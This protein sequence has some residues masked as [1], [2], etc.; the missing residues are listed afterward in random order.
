MLAKPLHPPVLKPISAHGGG[1]LSPPYL[2]FKILPFC[3]SRRA[4]IGRRTGFAKRF[5][6]VAKSGYT[7]IPM[8]TSGAYQLVD[9]ETGEKFIVWGGSDDG[10]DSPIPSK[11]VLSWSSSGPGRGKGKEERV[12]VG[13]GSGADI[14]NEA[15]PAKVAAAAVDESSL[16]RSFS[17]L[18]VQRVK[19]L[20][21]RSCLKHDD[22][23]DVI[24]QPSAA[25]KSPMQ[26]EK[27]V[28]AIRRGGK[29]LN[30]SRV[31]RDVMTARNDTETRQRRSELSNR[32]VSSY[33]ESK[34]PES[35]GYN[36][37]F[38]GWRN[39]RP[40]QSSTLESNDRMRSS[41][42][43]S[44]DGDFYSR[45]SFVDLGCNDYLI[46]SLRKQMFLRPSHIQAM[47]FKPVMEGKSCIIA[48]QS[49]S[50]KTL[51]YLAP[52]VQRLREEELQGQSKS[53]P[54]S[55]RVVILAP[56]AELASQVLNNCRSISKCG[57]PFRSIVTTGGFRQKTQLEAIEEGVDVLIATPG[58]FMYLIKEGFMELG[59]LRCVILDEV[60]ILCKD[61][62]FEAA[63][64]NLISSSPVTT[65][66]LFVTATLPVDTYNKLVDVFPDCEVIMGPGI[67]RTSIRLEEVLVDCSGEE[68]NE[69]SPDT[70]F[71]NK[72]SALV[73]LVEENPVPKTI[74]FCNK[75]E[76]CRKVENT[77]KR[78]DR[79]GARIRVLPFHSAVAQETRL[80]SIKDFIAG[81]SKDVSLFLVCTD[82][83]SRGIDFPEVDH[84]ILFDY[85]RDPSEY[86]RRVGRT[87]RGASGKGTAFVFAV[88]KQVMLARKVMDRNRKGHPLHDVP[89][90]YEFIG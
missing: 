40:S 21:K 73:Q 66:Y 1:T 44:A 41:R 59:N 82:R 78:V 28:P 87:A 35:D 50:G 56:T 80:A 39:G 54:R 12:K 55:P 49:G 25:S 53:L 52:L 11:D 72:K 10:P 36:S 2:N 63:L 23:E 62:D 29:D 33:A 15:S 3:L 48:D 7:R 42:K 32:K 64:Q 60:D 77:L 57:V 26:E 4:H 22:I 70:A 20:A 85:P 31:P 9:E 24:G 30:V 71:S 69:K 76:T 45:K 79:K 5:E 67:H 47:A 65:Q 34:Y 81:Q 14:E 46:E 37:G 51:A 61:E 16:R 17:R 6:I 68:E 19:A 86:V 83:A 90:A 75:I 27:E 13:G 88:G 74:I 43:F 18:K 84:V 38:R 8:E 89:A 58:R